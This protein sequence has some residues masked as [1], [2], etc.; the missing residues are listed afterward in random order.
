M[1]TVAPRKSFPRRLWEALKS[2]SLIV[3]MVINLV[4]IVVVVILLNQIGGIK[5]TLS[6]ILGQLDSA[7]EGL[8]KSTI[9]DTIVISQT[10]PVQFDLP[11]DQ[12]TSVVTQGPVPINAQATFSLGQF[13]SINGTVSL[14]LPQGTSLPVHLQLSV[15]V[16]TTIPVVFD[17]PIS[18]NLYQKGLASVV[19]KLRAALA[20]LIS[21]IKKLPDAFVIFP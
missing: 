15:P 3:S 17:Q 11:L 19:D 20:P 1:N 5:T 10:V 2:L 12:N 9:V 4:L 8:G 6:S 21:L 13:G 14:A 16:S 18:I 7:F